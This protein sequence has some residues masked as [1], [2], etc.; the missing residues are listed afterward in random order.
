M[1]NQ[2]RLISGCQAEWAALPKPDKP[3]TVGI[4]GGYVPDCRD[5]KT[6]FE[7]IVAKSYSKTRA[8]KRLGFVQKLDRK[9]G[10]RLLAMLS[11]QGLLPHQQITFL[12]DGADNLRDL[13][14]LMHPEA[15]HV[16]DWFHVAMRFTVLGQFAKGLCATDPDPGHELTELLKSAKW[17]LWHGNVK[18]AL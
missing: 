18:Q 1:E 10:Q 16:L 12:S 9:S 2:P 5:R 3:L 11:R 6:N 7:V 8:P 4:D 13:Q 14:L 15:E 17:Y